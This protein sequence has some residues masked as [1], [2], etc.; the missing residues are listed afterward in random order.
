[1]SNM[2]CAIEK[3]LIQCDKKYK[4]LINRLFFTSREISIHFLGFGN[5][6]GSF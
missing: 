6:S 2:V 4:L 1:M 3:T 5:F